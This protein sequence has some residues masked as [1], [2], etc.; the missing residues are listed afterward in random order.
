MVDVT[1][2]VTPGI[3]YKL[4][5][6][7]WSGNHE[8][9]TETLQ[10]MVRAEVG[11]PAN[12]VRIGDNLKDIQKLYGSRGYVAA[13]IKPDAEFDDAAGTVVL[14]YGCEGRR[15]ISHG[16]TRISRPRQQSYGETTSCLEDPF[17]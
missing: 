5:S 16:R 11:Q 15:R 13:T 1:F 10:K 8:L 12:T 6:V 3:Q 14:A 2:A 17:G 9:S 4:K 7:E